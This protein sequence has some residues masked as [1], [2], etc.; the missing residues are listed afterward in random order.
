MKIVNLNEQQNVSVYDKKFI[1]MKKYISYKIEFESSKIDVIVGLD[2]NSSMLKFNITADWHQVGN[3]K[4]GIPQLN[5]YAPF[6]GKTD[7]YRYDIP[8]G[9]IDR[10]EKNHDMPGN[11]FAAALT[12]TPI[13]VVTDTKYGF[14][15]VDNSIAVSLIRSSYD[16]DPYPE[17]GV[18][19]INIG[20]TV[21]N[22]CSV[23]TLAKARSEL[24]HPLHVV[25]GKKRKGSLP[26]EFEFLKL[27]GDL[28]VSSVK[29]AE[30]SSDGKSAIIRLYNANDSIAKAT[31]ELAGRIAKAYIVDI[32]EVKQT[33]LAVYSNSIALEVLPY[34]V[35][36]IA[37]E[38]EENK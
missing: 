15:T 6:S 16:P 26:L 14:R 23:E 3:E 27:S 24:V 10:E 21:L 18:H 1:G 9:V 13:M 35:V 32:N 8:F 29:S 33:D 30:N 12:E 28:L 22:D 19:H 36:T 17:Y 7:K 37:V 4:S 11:S 20:L 5:F 2:D 38:L 34:E 31:I 25:S